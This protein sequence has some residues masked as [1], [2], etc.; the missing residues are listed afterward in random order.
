MSE[1]MAM[2][3]ASSPPLRDLENLTSKAKQQISPSD[4]A[5]A[6]IHCDRFTYLYGLAKFT[7]D[8]NVFKELNKHAMAL[9]LS[10]NFEL[11]PS[12]SKYTAHLL[13]LVALKISLHNYKCGKCKGVGQI[14]N[15]N[16]LIVCPSCSGIGEKQISIR[17]L[18][19]LLSVS[20]YRT[21]KIW[22]QRLN[23]L[24]MEYSAMESDIQEILKLGLR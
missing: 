22:R 18:S 23:K 6:L 16:T 13:G 3:T 5:A 9:S 21:R 11:K 8:E 15:K 14:Q 17:K 12:E 10:H 4:V 24:L 7:L 1:L 2:L 19:Q 20:Q